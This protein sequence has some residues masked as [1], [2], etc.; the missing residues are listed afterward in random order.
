MRGKI[1]NRTYYS[2]L[3]PMSAIPNL[4]KF[5]DWIGL[6]PEDREQRV[7][8]ESRV[9]DLKNYILETMSSLFSAITALYKSPPVFM[10]NDA[11]VAKAIRHPEAETRRR[12]CHQ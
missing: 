1:G 7:L 6:R 12:A 11:G 9:P 8:D 5:T 10:P 4:F 3:M 2:C